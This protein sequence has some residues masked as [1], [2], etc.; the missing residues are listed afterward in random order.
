LC[1]VKVTCYISVDLQT[2]PP[3]PKA[4]KLERLSKLNQSLSRLQVDCE[5]MLETVLSV[6]DAEHQITK[7]A[8]DVCHLLRRMRGELDRS[9]SEAA[10]HRVK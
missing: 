3:I 8:V 7:R 9:V 5:E 6:C 1:F 4:I 10:I 2:P